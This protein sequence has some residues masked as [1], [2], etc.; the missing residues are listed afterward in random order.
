MTVYKDH[1]MVITDLDGTLL[2]HDTYDASAAIPIIRQ[3]QS[4]NIPIIFNTSKTYKE[5]LKIRQ[6]LDIHDPFIVEN[7]SCIFFPVDQFPDMPPDTFRRDDYWS[8]VLGSPYQQICNIFDVIDTHNSDY[9]RFSQCTI[10]QAVKLTGLTKPS[11]KLAINREFSEPV[12]WHADE[13]LLDDFIRQL[14]KHSLTAQQ[15]GRFLHVMGECSK[16]RSVQTLLKYYKNHYKTIILGDSENDADMLAVADIS[17][18]VNSPTSHALIA[19]ITPDM[20]S[21]MNAPEGWAEAI[22]KILRNLERI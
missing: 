15:G 3:L 12:K 5:T 4:N 22:Q 8:V 14:K 21:Q 16:G 19:K 20:Q 13:S 9:T 6:E 11:V 2:N 1:W 10:E 17:A 18:V 7:G